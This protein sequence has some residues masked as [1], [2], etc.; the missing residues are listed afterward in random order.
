MLSNIEYLDMMA[1]NVYSTGASG[2]NE[3]RHDL[4]NWVNNLLMLNCTKIEQLGS[5]AAYCQI[6]DSLWPGSVPLSKVKFDAKHEHE[7]VVNFKV[8]QTAFDKKKIDKAIPVDR[9]VKGR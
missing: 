8:L 5:G 1:N 9:L 3:S 2:G 4:L 6:I 7:F